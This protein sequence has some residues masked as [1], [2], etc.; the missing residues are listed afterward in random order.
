M[1]RFLYEPQVFQDWEVISPCLPSWYREKLLTGLRPEYRPRDGFEVVHFGWE[2]WELWEWARGGWRPC[3][4][5]P[6]FVRKSYPPFSGLLE[7]ENPRLDARGDCFI[8]PF[9]PT[10]HLKYNSSS[11]QVAAINPLPELRLLW[12]FFMAGN[13]DL[14]APY[15]DRPRRDGA[16][17]LMTSDDRC[18][19]SASRGLSERTTGAQFLGLH[20]LMIL[21]NSSATRV[22]GIVTFTTS[23]GRRCR[24]PLLGLGP[25]NRNLNV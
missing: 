11:L 1:A 14:L 10:L 7:K 13:R 12:H 2:F 9:L 22:G 19:H 6:C 5:G 8:S 16:D 20:W 15:L 4:R 23:W 24:L 25:Q 3:W 18:S 21:C 17:L